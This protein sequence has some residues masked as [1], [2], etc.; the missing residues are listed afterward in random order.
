MSNAPAAANALDVL[1]HLSR[2]AEPVPA[3]SVARDLVMFDLLR[4]NNDAG[5]EDGIFTVFFQDFRTFLDEPLHR[6]AD[7]AFRVF[8]KVLKDLFQ[9]FNMSFRL[10]QM[11]FKSVFQFGV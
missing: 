8:I 11:L 4:G 10:F 7:L 2:H 9:S 3:A 1:E 5:I 6:M